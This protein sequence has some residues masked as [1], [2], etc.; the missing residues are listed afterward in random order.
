MIIRRERAEITIVDFLIL[1]D[2]HY[3]L[4]IERQE[5]PKELIHFEESDRELL[6]ILELF[7]ESAPAVSLLFFREGVED[8][9]EKIIHLTENFFSFF[10]FSS[11]REYNSRLQ[12][13]APEKWV[14]LT[15]E[16]PFPLARESSTN[17]YSSYTKG[18]PSPGRKGQAPLPMW[19]QKT[20]EDQKID[21]TGVLRLHW[22]LIKKIERNSPT[23]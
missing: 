23:I 4:L 5:N 22:E 1:E 7:L 10:N 11:D 8:F 3:R 20:Q 21:L 9:K 12:V 18:H 16:V 15:V 6:L 19:L 14:K 13:Y 2:L 17:P